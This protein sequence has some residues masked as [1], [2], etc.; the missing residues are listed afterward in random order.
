[1][2]TDSRTHRS[3]AI[4]LFAIALCIMPTGAQAE[5]IR[6]VSINAWSGLTYRGV[7]SVGR[8]EEEAARGF[9]H[10]LL[11]RRLSE[12]QPDIVG[13]NE[14]NPLPALAR[15]IAEALQYAFVYRVRRGGVR[16]GPVGLPAN[17]REGDLVLAREAYNLV[18]AGSESL[19]GGP[20]GNVVSFQF[21]DA[22]QIL[23]ATVST[24]G[25]T[26]H[27]FVT[28][29]HGSQFDNL[30]SL[31]ELAELYAAGDI[32]GDAYYTAVRDAVRGSETRLEQARE[33]LVFINKVAGHEP[34]VLMGTLN[35]LPGS[36]EIRLIEEAGFRD[37]WKEAGRG[38]GYTWD[39]LTNSNILEF[40][41]SDRPQQSKRRRIDYI[42]V[43]GD[44]IRVESAAV[45]LDSPTF[46]IHPSDHYGVA[47][48]LVIS[49]PA[50][51]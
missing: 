29:W 3:F 26:V 1:M 28:N 10:E 43:R 30:E 36:E 18:D 44:A 37:V 51:E 14:I 34:A 25:R 22:S 19:T 39:P 16:V 32:D 21:G 9:R 2:T 33:S 20:A 50:A 46:G 7:F 12:L 8:Y 40:G 23:A 6:V 5:S 41:S 31:K 49:E 42:F 24:A 4:L 47:A 45:V 17:L 48:D 13:L 15:S 35:A 38:E 11:T 27:V